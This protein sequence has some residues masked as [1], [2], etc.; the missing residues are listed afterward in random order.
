ML[1]SIRGQSRAKSSPALCASLRCAYNTE[2]EKQL[3]TSFHFL[4][5]AKEQEKPQ[6]G[7]GCC[8]TECV[9]LFFEDPEEEVILYGEVA[10]E[11][12][13]RED[14][15]RKQAQKTSFYS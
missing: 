12:N 14:P 11:G 2:R 13:N 5:R 1:Q 4:L 9:W 7:C 8:E 3:P 15:G 6:T 10:G